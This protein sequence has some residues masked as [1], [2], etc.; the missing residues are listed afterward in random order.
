MLTPVAALSLSV[1]SDVPDEVEVDPAGSTVLVADDDPSVRNLVALAFELDGFNVAS[2][3][4][5]REALDLARRL[6][7]AAVVLDAVMP[8]LDGMAVSRHLR[9]EQGRR[10]AVLILTGRTDVADRIAAFEAGADD[11]VVKPIRVTELVDR[12]KRH[13]HRDASRRPGR[14]LGSPE[15]YEDLRRRMRA[16]EAVAA[17]CVDVIGLR[18]FSRHYSYAR[19]ERVLSWIGDVLL[20]LSAPRASTVVGRLGAD[21]FLAVTTPEAVTQLAGDLLA[22]FD[23]TVGTFYDPVDADRGWIDVTDRA[24]RTRRH[25]PLTLAVGVAAN[26]P[27]RPGHHL[28]LVERAAEMA[29]YAGRGESNRVAVDRRS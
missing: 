17:M 10:P 13:L 7:P 4:D 15:I 6:R 5:G 22:A 23:V 12:V 1:D 21:E 28:E 16:G 25:R 14:L 24:G 11:Y 20:G 26:D 18:P 3:I 19:A 8:H 2:A 9:A 29:R 27:A